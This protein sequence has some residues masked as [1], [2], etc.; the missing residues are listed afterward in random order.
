MGKAALEYVPKRKSVIVRQLRDELLLYDSDTN[1]AHGLNS[2]AAKVWRLCDGRRSVADII[3]TLNQ[4]D[5]SPL[6]ESIVWAALT[7]LQESKLLLN[8]VPALATRNVLSRRTVIRRMGGAAMALVPVITSIL[9]PTPA[10]AAS[11]CRHN[12]QPCPQGNSQC[13][14][15]LCVVG[16]CVG[17]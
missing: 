17:G 10:E 6:A 13:C 12:L 16:F 8:Q 11:P 2:V 9:V 15:N 3:R 14:S 7:R 5:D 4:K 1:N